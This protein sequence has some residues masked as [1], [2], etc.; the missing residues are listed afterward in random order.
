MST[1]GAGAAV[2][3]RAPPPLP[4]PPSTQDAGE[5]KEEEEEDDYMSDAFLASVSGG[6]GSSGGVD[7]GGVQERLPLWKR[8]AKEELQAEHR[9]AQP[10]PNKLRKIEAIARERTAVVS[11]EEALA[12]PLSQ[13]N[14]GFAMLMKMGFKKGDGLGKDGA[15]IHE[16]INVNLKQGRAGLGYVMQL[17]A[18]K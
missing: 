14:K 12:K 8:K 2:V 11:R 3:Q 5:K 6:G 10:P 9:A 17:N 4:P 13:S 18:L 7:V 16:P 1:N 15:G